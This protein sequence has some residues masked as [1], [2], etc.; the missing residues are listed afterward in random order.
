[1]KNIKAI[2]TML[3]LGTSAAA[4][5]SP[6]NSQYAPDVRDHRE[7]TPVTSPDVRDHR[8]PRPMPVTPAPVQEQGAWQHRHQTQWTTLASSTKI[9]GNAETIRVGKRAGSFDQIKLEQVSGKTQIKL[10]QINFSNGQS[11]WVRLNTQLDRTNTVA[12]IT[13]NGQN[14]QIS[15]IVV[16]GSG[17]ARSA[18]SILA[19]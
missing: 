3:V 4:F 5:A 11:Q 13:L 14:R 12:A 9:V 7:P 17:N 6:G 1:M 8:M 2:I 10:V 15:S 16:Y 19:A 18:Y